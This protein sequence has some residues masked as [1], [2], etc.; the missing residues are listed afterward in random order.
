MREFNEGGLFLLFNSMLS[1][2]PG[3]LW[4]RWSRVFEVTRVSE[5]GAVEVWSESTGK[6][7][8]NSQRLK[9]YHP[10]DKMF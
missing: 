3:K 10:S 5:L 9:H 1:L 2:F 7:I 4:S 6:F 8:V